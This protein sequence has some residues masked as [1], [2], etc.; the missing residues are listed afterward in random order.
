MLTDLPNVVGMTVDEAT[1]DARGR[2]LRRR[3]SAS[4][5]T[6]SEAEGIVAAQN[7]GAGK[8]AGGTTVTINPSNGQGVS[9][10]DVAGMQLDDAIS[11]LRGAGFGNVQPGTC[12]E[13]D[14]RRAAAE[15][16]RHHP[17]GRD[18]S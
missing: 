8:V 2:R 13:D 4:P 12:T 6:P 7:P 11:D 10:P 1:S 5:S 3:S 9:V 17:G 16:D 14:V 18:A 15:G